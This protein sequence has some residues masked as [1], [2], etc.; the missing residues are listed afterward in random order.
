MTQIVHKPTR[1][2]LLRTCFTSPHYP[3]LFKGHSTHDPALS[4]VGQ[5]VPYI[6]DPERIRVIIASALPP[7]Y[8]G[9]TL[10]EVEQMVTSAMD[11]GFDKRELGKLPMTLRM[12]LS[13]RLSWR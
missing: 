2:T 3:E 8:Q 7:D 13:R 4:F 5:L 9:N 6:K 12:H 11:K 1:V 10:E